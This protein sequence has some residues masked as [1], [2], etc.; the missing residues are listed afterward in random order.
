AIRFHSFEVVYLPRS[1]QRF[2][3]LL[4]EDIL[5]QFTETYRIDTYIQDTG[6]WGGTGDFL[7]KFGMKVNDQVNL[8][9]SRETFIDLIP[10]QSRPM[11]GDWIYFPHPLDA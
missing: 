4:N 8:M 1:L 11:E 3:T 5:S 10:E 2:D 7:T 6:G 9:I